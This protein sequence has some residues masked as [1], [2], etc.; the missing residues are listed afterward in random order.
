MTPL[1]VLR[2]AYIEGRLD[3]FLYDGVFQHLYEKSNPNN[4]D[5]RPLRKDD[6]S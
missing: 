2:F 1:R 3:A 4:E 6:N 5:K